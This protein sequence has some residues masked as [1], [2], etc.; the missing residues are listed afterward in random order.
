MNQCRTVLHSWTEPVERV[1]AAAQCRNV[2][3]LVPRETSSLQRATESTRSAL[4]PRRAIPQAGLAPAQVIARTENPVMGEFAVNDLV[5]D[6]NKV[7]ISVIG[8]PGKFPLSSAL[9]VVR[10]L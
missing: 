1:L 5:V 2:G 10:P 8:L 6:Q 3:V 7:E 4:R 9:R